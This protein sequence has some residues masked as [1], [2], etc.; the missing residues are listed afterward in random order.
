MVASERKSLI[1]G[2]LIDQREEE[3]AMDVTEK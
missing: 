2:S 1:N 3:R